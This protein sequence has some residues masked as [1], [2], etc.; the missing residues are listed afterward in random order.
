[1]KVKYWGI[2]MWAYPRWCIGGRL[3]TLSPIPLE[4]TPILLL[5]MMPELVLI[6]LP[7]IVSVYSVMS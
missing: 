4:L 3:G 7:I 6:L 2:S 1:M 5:S